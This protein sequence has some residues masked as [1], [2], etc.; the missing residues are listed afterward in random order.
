MAVQIVENLQH[1]YCGSHV[2]RQKNAYQLVFNYIIIRPCVTTLAK[3][4]LMG[5]LKLHGLKNNL[6]TSKTKTL[7]ETLKTNKFLAVFVHPDTT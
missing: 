6:P 4:H 1:I 3:S 5:F 7:G 2:G